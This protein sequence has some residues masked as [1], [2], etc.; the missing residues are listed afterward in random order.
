[1]VRPKIKILAPMNLA[2][3]DIQ[4]AYWDIQLSSHPAFCGQERYRPPAFQGGSD[5]SQLSR[6]KNTQLSWVFVSAFWVQLSG[7]SSV[8]GLVMDLAFW[9]DQL[10]GTVSVKP[11]FLGIPAF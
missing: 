11:S 10:S 2:Y 9:V 6:T 3:W 4:L 8:L 7:P 1:M 5:T